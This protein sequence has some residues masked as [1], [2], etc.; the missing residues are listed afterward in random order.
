MVKKRNLL[1]E[2]QDLQSDA[3]PLVSG[4]RS[5]R[6]KAPSRLLDEILTGSVAK[7]Y[8]EGV[9]DMDEDT[10]EESCCDDESDD[11]Y[12]PEAEEEKEEKCEKTQKIDRNEDED[13]EDEEQAEVFSVP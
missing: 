5:N 10:E 13:E 9:E 11:E 8:Y 12:K 1:S 7:E 6:G 2:L 3:Q 4:K